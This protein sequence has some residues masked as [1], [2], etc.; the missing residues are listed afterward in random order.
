ML[1]LVMLDQIRKQTLNSLY[2]L[3]PYTRL[4]K[5]LNMWYLSHVR[6]L[7]KEEK[8]RG[9]RERERERETLTVCE[10]SYQQRHLFS[11]K[12]CDKEKLCASLHI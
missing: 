3:I 1:E 11:H 6:A 7:D 2:N 8:T 5:Y 9:E 4:I 12:K 10:T